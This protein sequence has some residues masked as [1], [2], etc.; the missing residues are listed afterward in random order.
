MC[1]QPAAS[2]ITHTSSTR[3]T[4]DAYFIPLL[5]AI[6]K[7]RAALPED[8]EFFCVKFDTSRFEVGAHPASHGSSSRLTESMSRVAL[9]QKRQ[10]YSELTGT[11]WFLVAKACNHPNWLVAF[12]FGLIKPAA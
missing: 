8:W 12:R 5:K 4:P 7:N 2:F 1:P 3:F 6:K 10:G 9:P 11:E